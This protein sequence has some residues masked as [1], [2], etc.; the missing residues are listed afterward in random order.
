M[1][2]SGRFP[3]HDHPSH[4]PESPDTPGLGPQKLSGVLASAN[5]PAGDIPRSQIAEV[6]VYNLGWTGEA[7][8]RID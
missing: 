1:I 8:P 4:A 6:G 5:L 2:S 7:E 3:R